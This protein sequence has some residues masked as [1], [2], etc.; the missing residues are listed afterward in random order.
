MPEL[1]ALPGEP[2]VKTYDELLAY[3]QS[4]E[5]Q[6][7]HEIDKSVEAHNASKGGDIDNLKRHTRA[8]EDNRRW[9]RDTI[10]WLK[11]LKNRH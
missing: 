3:W 9:I 5:R 8:L 7:V 4:K 10:S 2:S 6:L 11:T 1:R